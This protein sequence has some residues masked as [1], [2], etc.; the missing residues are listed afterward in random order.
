MD[1]QNYLDHM[2]RQKNHT[3]Q[4]KPICE[5][6][7]MPVGYTKLIDDPI[8]TRVTGHFINGLF[9]YITY[10]GRLLWTDETGFIA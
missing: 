8:R 9:M 6:I 2:N 4:I 1:E 5:F 3:T 10:N 7:G